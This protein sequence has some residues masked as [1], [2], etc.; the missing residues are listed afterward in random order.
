MS[1]REVSPAHA[2]P[3]VSSRARGGGVGALVPYLAANTFALLALY[4]MWARRLIGIGA[5]AGDPLEPVLLGLWCLALLLAAS[6]IAGGL[7]R[8]VAR[9]APPVTW[10]LPLVLGSTALLL[11]AYLD[12]RAY[13]LLGVHLYS[14]AVSAAISRAQLRREL[15]LSPVGVYAVLGAFVLLCG[16]QALLLFGSTRLWQ[17]L[18]TAARARA[19]LFVALA[20]LVAAGG[21]L[22]LLRHRLSSPTSGLSKALPLYELAL[23]GRRRPPAFRVAYPTTT[24]P[25][26]LAR[27]PNILLVAVESWRADTFGAGSMPELDRWARERGCLRSTR[28]YAGSHRTEFSIFS[29]LYGL[30][31]YHYLPFS[32]SNTPSLPLRILADNGYRLGGASASALAG[33]IG[34]RFI[35]DQLP[36]YR[37]FNDGEAWQDDAN[38]LAWARRFTA[39]GSEPWFLFLFLNSTH[40]SYSYPPAYERALPVVARMERFVD[41]SDSPAFREGLH[42]RYRNSISYLD[43]TLTSALE[44][45]AKAGTIVVLTGD[46]GEEF[47]EAGQ[48]GHFAPN[49]NEYRTRTPLLLCLPD[50]AQGEVRLS[51]HADVMPTLF[52]LLLEEPTTDAPL[53]AD[54]NGVS[55]LRPPPVDRLIAIPGGAFPADDD[56][57]CLLTPERKYWLRQEPDWLDRFVLVRTTDLDDRPRHDPDDMALRA[58]IDRLNH[59]LTL[60]LRD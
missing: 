47:W 19:A 2:D 38:M 30:D 36:G 32:A 43:R 3:A 41:Q 58:L 7:A 48:W 5:V 55:L 57:V 31:A 14:P 60:H 6:L 8:L 18:G 49:F 29:L 12:I 40:F 45:L 11:G 33:W 10:Q 15:H 52:D 27:R 56:L 20:L 28:N 51:S 50:G 22:A 21:T 53:A 46:H 23:S 1:A 26:H 17:R 24:A 35:V 59:R 13:V 44:A 16:I 34:A 42:N 37:E 4:V 25:I 54:M 9:L 39:A